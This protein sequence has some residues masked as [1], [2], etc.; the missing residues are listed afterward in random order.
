MD[1]LDAAVGHRV[2]PIRQHPLAASSA[3]ARAH[4]RE[5]RSDPGRASDISMDER[6]RR[7]QRKG[8]VEMQRSLSLLMV[9]GIA[10]FGADASAQTIKDNDRSAVAVDASQD[11]DRLEI[12]DNDRVTTTTVDKDIRTSEKKIDESFQDNSNDD[13]NS[14]NRIKMTSVL[15]SESKT[16]SI[17]ES[18][19]LENVGNGLTKPVAAIELHGTVTNNRVFT[20]AKTATSGAVR[21]DG[22]FNEFKGINSLN[23]NT[24][25]NAYQQTAVAVSV[26]HISR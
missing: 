18:T 12:E 9:L 6:T 1:P 10:A 17:D 21:F 4:G 25:A 16:I 26:A 14:D 5:S 11:N 7:P 15:K 13:V 3:R 8:E 22:S 24:G 19:K 23:S 2:S 20:L